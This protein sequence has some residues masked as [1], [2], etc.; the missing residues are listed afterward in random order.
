MILKNAIYNTLN[1]LYVKIARD[2]W[3]SVREGKGLKKEG[4]KE[5]IEEATEK[6]LKLVEEAK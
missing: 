5:R 3:Q 1:D 2:H 4:L 6:I